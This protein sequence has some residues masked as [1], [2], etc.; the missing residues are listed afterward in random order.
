MEQFGI[1]VTREPL[2]V[3]GLDHAETKQFRMRFLTHEALTPLLR[4]VEDYGHVAEPFTHPRGPSLSAGSKALPHTGFVHLGLLDEQT[5]DIDA[6]SVLGIRHRRPHSLCDNT[7]G[8]LGREFEY[9][10]RLF[11]TFAA[12]LID[13]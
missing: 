11:D 12:N 6:L 1:I 3:P 10:Q 8:A 2:R 9:V 4:F 5:I 7:R 13:H